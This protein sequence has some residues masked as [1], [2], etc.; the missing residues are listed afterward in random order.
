MLSL[1]LKAFLGLMLI[2]SGWLVGSLYPAPEQWTSAIRGRA[3]PLLERMD[4]SPEG[5]DRLRAALSPDDFERLG[6]DAARLAASTGDAIRIER[7]PEAVLEE[8]ADFALAAPVVTASGY[9]TFENVLRLCPG[10]TVSN[11]PRAGA[12]NNVEGYARVIDVNGVAIAANPTHG[13]CLSS[14]VGRR[15]GRTHKGLDLYSR[16]GG[17]VFAAADGVVIEKLYRDDYGNMLLIDHGGGVYTRYAHLSSFAA[18]LSV[19]AR[20][21]AGQQIGLMGNTASYPIPVHLHY[22]LLLGDY[23]NPR[24]SFGLTPR[25]PF[26]F[27]SIAIEPMQATRDASASGV[28]SDGRVTASTVVTIRRGDTIATIARSCYGGVDAWRQVVRC[29]GFLNERNRG[30]VS[31]LNGGDLLYVGDRL[32][33]PAPDGACPAQ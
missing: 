2:G 31:P 27:A 13:A 22:E 8:H 7:T 6:E 10:M 11:A 29:N 28:C 32:M 4:V 12:D 18:A 1:V 14:G 17:P 24:G 33:L 9:E 23:A 20:V 26:D 15:G 5:L 16:E 3:V 25:S 19:G 30:G 21:S